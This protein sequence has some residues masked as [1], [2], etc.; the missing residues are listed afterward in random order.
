[1]ATLSA[2]MVSS[3][4]HTYGRQGVGKM[5]ASGVDTM[6]PARGVEMKTGGGVVA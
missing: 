4:A 6:I 2:I 1:M 5:T 3:S